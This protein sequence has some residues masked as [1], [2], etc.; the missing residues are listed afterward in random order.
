M[1]RDYRIRPPGSKRNAARRRHSQAMACTV[2]LLATH[3]L[4][5]LAVRGLF[6]DHGNT[7]NFGLYPN[8]L[9]LSGIA[10]PALRC[11]GA[12]GS[13]RSSRLF[14]RGGS[15]GGASTQAKCDSEGCQK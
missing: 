3:P 5:V 7:R 6:A 14:G 10:I 15:L 12:G 13:S 4:G 9:E 2:L 1:G 8:I 11:L